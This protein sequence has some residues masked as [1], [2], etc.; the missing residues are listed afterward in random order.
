MGNAAPYCASKAAVIALT[1]A[2]SHE[3][4]P[5]IRVIC[6]APKAT[7]TDMLRKYHPYSPGDPPEKVAEYILSAIE[8]GKNGE[9][10]VVE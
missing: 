9:C 2:L 4:G 8:K 10:M 5:R 7:N 3:L 1:K 6:V